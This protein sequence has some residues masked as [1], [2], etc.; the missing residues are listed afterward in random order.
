MESSVAELH[1]RLLGRYSLGATICLV[2]IL[3]YT[4]TFFVL[5]VRL[6]KE[7]HM[8]IEDL[9]HYDQ[10]LYNS[11]HGRFLETSLMN[12]QG[13]SLFAFHFV[14]IML[15]VLPIYALFAHTYVLF[16]LQAL[17]AGLGALAVFSLARERM[18]DELAATC[19]ALAYL[20]HPSLQGATLNLFHLGFH[21]GHFFPP[22]LLFAFHFLLKERYRC[23]TWFFLLALM[24]QET[25]AVSLAALGLYTLLT[26]A[27]RRRVG[28]TILC[29]SFLWFLIANQVVIPYFRALSPPQPPEQLGPTQ[30]VGAELLPALFDLFRQPLSLYLEMLRHARHC[31]FYLLV[32]LAFLPLAHIPSL[33][34]ILPY[35]FVN[36][37]ALTADYS[38]PLLPNSWHVT[39]II[40]F[41][42]IS[43]VLGAERLSRWAKGVH[44]K[45]RL[46]RTWPLLVLAVS[47]L[48]C[49]WYGPL[50]FSR[51]VHP[52]RYV[53]DE[54]AAKGVAEVK[55]LIPPEASLA[56]EKGIGS[57]FTQRRIL[58]MLRRDSW[59]GADY[60]LLN[61]NPRYGGTISPRNRELLPILEKS[62]CYEL[63]Y[64]ENNILLFRQRLP[65][66]EHP[67]SANLGNM[68]Q[69]LG[70]DLSTD[71]LEPGDTLQ[72]IVYW[73]AL[74]KIQVNY[75]IFT[76]LIDEDDRI[77]GQKD[78]W[79]VNNTY[80]TTKWVKGEIVTDGHEI[81]INEDA[82]PGE[83][84]LEIGMYD[85]ATNERVSIIDAQVQAK[86]NAVILGYVW[87]ES[88]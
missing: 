52:D 57:N 73:Q 70:Y 5:Q 22:L 75:T 21:P 35:L 46:L 84:T 49:Y 79:P 80:P 44:L 82:P 76:R 65:P 39:P 61:F 32:P 66:M 27:R 77:W 34:T 85:L 53:V 13:G 24:V 62:P 10:P 38:L 33:L 83:Y 7:L 88:P 78:N 6:Y 40:P 23:F 41:V 71:R 29:V 54:S 60:V 20:L 37:M 15:F 9:G 64:A 14:P 1:P 87:V 58:L 69:L 48:A 4:L 3:L 43:A 25:Y 18:K 16:F 45:G 17:A 55:T 56:A 36:L 50:P 42:F 67:L 11:L 8:R 81:M 59:K 72:L 51:T 86:D 12:P 28:A 63:I 19:L 68:V 26:D 31:L 47:V 2:A 74:D 30:P